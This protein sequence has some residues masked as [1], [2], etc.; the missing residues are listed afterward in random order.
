MNE[1]GGRRGLAFKMRW[2]EHASLKGNR[3]QIN[4]R[5]TFR[6]SKHELS[7]STFLTDFSLN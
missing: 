2:S 5:V 7:S 6:S 4:R 1:A 3:V